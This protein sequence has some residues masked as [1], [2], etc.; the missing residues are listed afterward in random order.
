M[1]HSKSKVYIIICT[2]TQYCSVVFQLFRFFCLFNKRKAKNRSAKCFVGHPSRYIKIIKY[3]VGHPIVHGYIVYNQ[4]FVKH[5]SGYITLIKYF[6][7][8]PS[9]W[10]HCL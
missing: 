5:P 1:R 2:H 4:F 10:L 3:C 7:G 6:V 8:H 9:A